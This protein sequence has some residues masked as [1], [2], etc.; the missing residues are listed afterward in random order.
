MDEPILAR[1]TRRRFLA[2]LGLAAAGGAATALAANELVRTAGSAQSAASGAPLTALAGSLPPGSPRPSATPAPSPDYSAFRSHYRSRPDLTPPQVLVQVPAGAVTPG[3]LFYTPSN[4]SGTDGPAI[5]TNNGDLVWMRP[6][7]GTQ[8]TN[9][10]AVDLAGQ[11][12]L[13]WWEGTVNGGIGTGDVVLADSTY[14]EISRVRAGNGRRADLHEFQLTSQGTALLLADA[15]VAATGAP[16]GTGLAGQVMDCAVQ[17]IDLQTG[18]VRFEWHTITDIAIDESFVDPPADPTASIYDYVH[19]NSIE[20][21]RDGTLLVSARNTST[22]YK[23]DRLTGAIVWRL[24]GKRS[25][26]RMGD[27]AG[28]SWQHDVRRQ[29]DGTLTI[30]DDS[31]SPGHSR[32]IVLQVDEQ[33]RTATLVRAFEHPAPLLARSQGNVQVLP[34]GNVLVGWGD[35][36]YVSE[37]AANGKVVFDATYPAAGQSYRNYRLAWTGRPADPPAVAAV[38]GPGGSVTVFASWNGATE[39]ATWDVHA[40]PSAGALSLAGSMPRSGFETSIPVKGPAQWVQV[41]ARNARGAV[42]GSSSIVN[43]PA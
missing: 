43:V 24:G 40:G 39:V 8:V 2:F 25:D 6:D 31:A 18:A 41:V 42:L 11:P 15:G 1:L 16:G 9:F 21:D 3:L 30:F 5:F 28:F 19:A 29:A 17:E 23:V 36:G 34:G 14:R 22:V 26:F 37:F 32:A 20:V 27:G 10:H 35:A 4:G 12:R 7:S 38:S 13:A 33:A